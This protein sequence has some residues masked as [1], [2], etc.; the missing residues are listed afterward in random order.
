M[1]NNWCELIRVKR[2]Y[3][4]S[5]ALDQYSLTLIRFLVSK[6]FDLAYPDDEV[7]QKEIESNIKS[8]GMNYSNVLLSRYEELVNCPRRNQDIEELYLQEIELFQ[9]EIQ[10]MKVYLVEHVRLL[11]R[12]SHVDESWDSYISSVSV[13]LPKIS[14]FRRKSTGKTYFQAF[15]SVVESEL[16]E[17]LDSSVTIECHWLIPFDF[18]TFVSLYSNWNT[19][20]NN[21]VASNVAL[22]VATNR[23]EMYLKLLKKS[24]DI[25]NNISNWKSVQSSVNDV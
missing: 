19:L 18:E 3:N 13:I 6:K 1:Y 22:G 7:F 21:S 8:R 16:R 12:N 20:R 25:T 5:D 17:K 15:R 23:L 14:S 10:R 2:T 24:S 4:K 9:A 11:P